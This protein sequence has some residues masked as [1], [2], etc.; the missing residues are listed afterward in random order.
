MPEPRCLLCVHAHPDDEA[1]F[2]AGVMARYAAAGVRSVLVTCT[3]GSLGFSPDG[4]GPNDAA[5]DRDVVA[6]SRRAELEAS[7]ALL[8]VDRLEVLGYR[9]S[10]M[11]GWPQNDEQGSFIRQDLDEVADRIAAVLAEERPQV[12]VTYDANGFYGHPDH[13]FTHLA[14]LAAI[15]RTDAVQKVYFPAIPESAPPGLPCARDGRRHGAAR[16]A[17]GARLGGPRRP[18]PHRGRLHAV[19]ACEARRPR[20]ARDPGGQH[21]PR[22]DARR[23]LRRRLRRGALRSRPRPD[24]D[25]PAR[26]RPVRRS[27]MTTDLT[28]VCV[29]AHPDDESSSTG[30]VL[31]TY[32]DEG[33]RT[34]LVTCTDG[35]LGDAPDGTTPETEGHDPAA[36]AAHRRVELRPRSASSA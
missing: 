33:I 16:V 29:H 17:G 32:A 9:D 6:A 34:V 27:A 30:G 19:G 23:G 12:V 15:E 18:R 4:T 31:R 11:A 24:P 25:A 20:R 36:V 22:P 8:G 5:H 13:V 10:G 3:D 26:G 1:L 28:M 2:T 14:T 35:A 21:R 7:C